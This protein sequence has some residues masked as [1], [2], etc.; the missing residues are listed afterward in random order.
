MWPGWST[1]PRSSPIRRTKVFH[2]R[3]QKA[4]GKA[5]PGRTA[6]THRESAPVP[7]RLGLGSVGHGVGDRQ[8]PHHRRQ[9]LPTPFAAIASL[10]DPHG[11]LPP[12]AYRG[13]PCL[14]LGEHPAERPTRGASRK[15]PRGQPQP[16][17]PQPFRPPVQRRMC[18]RA[19][20]EQPPRHRPETEMPT[21][22]VGP[23]QRHDHRHRIV[24]VGQHIARQHPHATPAAPAACQSNL[25]LELNAVDLAQRIDLEHAQP[26]PHPRAAQHQRLPTAGQPTLGVR[27]SRCPPDPTDPGLAMSRSCGNIPRW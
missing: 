20:T 27:D 4:A 2:R 6:P 21:T 7:E 22:G 11:H 16:M 17:G 13:H 24:F 5:Q 15:G 25:H 12:R 10:I 9:A 18:R 1:C 19:L 8:H 14:G 3:A 26:T 23:R